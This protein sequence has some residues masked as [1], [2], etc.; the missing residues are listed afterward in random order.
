MSK[1]HTPTKSH[2]GAKYKD[3][4]ARRKVLCGRVV[5]FEFTSGDNFSLEQWFSALGWKEYF[6]INVPYYVELVKEFYSNLLNVS[7]DYEYL[8]IKSKVSKTVI[9]FDDKLLGEILSVPADGSKFF[10]TMKWPEDPELVLEDCLKVFYPNENVFGGMA[11]PTNL[12]SAEHR[13]LHHIVATHVLPTSGGHEKMS[14]QDLYIMWHVVSGKPLNLP[15]L[16]MKNMLRAYSKI[17]G[18]LP[19]GMV[20][21]K[22]FAHFGIF[23]GNEFHSRIDV[24]DVYNASSLKKM[25]WKRV[26]EA[27]KGNVWLPKEGGRKRRVEEENVEEQSEP[28]RPRTTPASKQAT[29]SYSLSLETVLAEIKELKTKINKLDIKMDNLRG[30]LFDDQRRRHRRIEKKLV[31]KGVIEADDISESE[32]EEEEG[33]QEQ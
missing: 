19:Y 31:A 14:Y 29:S 30:E 20:I 33:S 4:Y 5:D 26:F 27:G 18:A 6:L 7:G 10:E 2:A 3:N 11:K 16:I 28:Q 15:N 25:S 17:D 23:P 1:K 24:G 21:T 22:I 12:L 9:K 13:L 8:E 32:E